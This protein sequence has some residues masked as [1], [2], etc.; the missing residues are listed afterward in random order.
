[1]TILANP[2]FSVKRATPV[3]SVRENFTDLFYVQ[4]VELMTSLSALMVK[5][6]EIK[7]T[8]DYLPLM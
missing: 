7:L 8:Q 5:N 3:P 4:R 1:V 6:E 2:Q